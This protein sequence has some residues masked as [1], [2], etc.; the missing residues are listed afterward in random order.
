[1]R[2]K[3]VS[4]LVASL[5]AVL[6]VSLS[7]AHAQEPALNEDSPVWVAAQTEAEPVILEALKAFDASLQTATVE[8]VE[9]GATTT[10]EVKSEGLDKNGVMLLVMYQDGKTVL[11][12]FDLNDPSKTKTD[13]FAARLEAALVKALDAKFKRG[14]L[15]PTAFVPQGGALLNTT[16]FGF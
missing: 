13:S 12:L 3:F 9:Q 15:E 7:S 10:R 2:F 6:A 14:N 11:G 8:V 5:V 16:A 4:S 1:M